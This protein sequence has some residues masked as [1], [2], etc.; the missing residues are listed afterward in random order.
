M[1]G[2]IKTYRSLADHWLAEQ[3]ERLGWW[4]LLLLKVSHEDKKVLVGN[5]LIELKRGQIITSYEKLSQLWKTSKKTAE[6]F[7]DVLEREQMLTRFVTHKVSV[8]TICN[9]ESYQD[10]KRGKVS[11]N[12]PDADPILTRL[13]STYK[14]DKEDKEINNT[15][16]AHAREGCLSWDA[17]REQGY[18]NTF[19]G[20]GSAIPFA[21]RVGKTPQEVMQLAE[22]YMATRELKDRGHN[23]YNEFVNL[24]LWHVENNKISIPVKTEPKKEKKVITNSDIFKVYGE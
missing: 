9:Y 15:N 24:F 6:R 14:E 12:C 22:I 17:I 2:W 18:F 8:L 5:H 1:S 23:D 4:I 3:P 11:D 7:V 13:V 20:Q 21:R 19:K 16:T 10:R